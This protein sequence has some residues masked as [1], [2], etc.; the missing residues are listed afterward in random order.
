MPNQTLRLRC[1]LARSDFQLQ[2]DL[3]LPARGITVLFGPSGSGKTTLLRCVAGLESATGLVRLG[4]TVWQDDARAYFVPTWRR[5]LGYV[6]QEPSLFEHLDVAQN[7]RFGLRRAR[8]PLTTEAIERSIELLGIGGLLKRRTN[9]LS[10]GERQRI[11][12]ARALV[13]QPQLLLLDEPLAS[14]DLARRLEI[15]PWLER[16]RDEWRVPM[17]YVTHSAEELA[18]LADHLVVLERGT[19]RAQGAA[20]TLLADVERPILYGDDT[21]VIL[22]GTV[23]A[24]DTQWHLSRVTFAGGNL[25][26]RDGGLRLQQAVRLRLLARDVSINTR[27]P[28]DTSIQ[29]HLRG[30]IETITGDVHPAQALVRIQCGPSSV[31]ARV[32]WRAIDALGLRTGLPIWAQVKSVAV[33]S[34][35]GAETGR[36]T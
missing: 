16:L 25:W 36:S 12:I 9:Q 18:R 1:A 24:I 3:E 8:N 5:Q 4:D 15:L 17:L 23:D 11:A 30:Q 6:F 2:V 20:Q 14:L 27:P 13:T 35:E 21:G 34:S 26:V 28:S 32:T 7:L 33:T 10:G 29:N 19:V 22:H 31:L